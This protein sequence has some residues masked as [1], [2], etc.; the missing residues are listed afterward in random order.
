LGILGGR[1]LQ[2]PL[3]GL[4]PGCNGFIVLLLSLLPAGSLHGQFVLHTLESLLDNLPLAVRTLDS[5]IPGE[6]LMGQLGLEI[7]DSS[8]RPL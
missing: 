4:L 5:L 1:H 7:V 8:P 6:P 2:Q 3:L